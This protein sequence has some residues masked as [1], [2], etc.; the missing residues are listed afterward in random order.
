[1]P[2]H[3]FFGSQ[4]EVGRSVAYMVRLSRWPS[5]QIWDP[6]MAFERFDFEMGHG[7]GPSNQPLPPMP[8][9]HGAGPSNQPLPPMPMQH[10]CPPPY[11][12]GG[13]SWWYGPDFAVAQQQQL[14]MPPP[15]Q[16]LLNP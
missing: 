12:H 5:S 8:M 11:N 10:L 9:Q 13:P 6:T 16:Q 3:S 4:R 15:S 1:M 2:W 7:A 14:P